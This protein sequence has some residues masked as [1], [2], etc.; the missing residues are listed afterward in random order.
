MRV[1]EKCGSASQKIVIAVR[2]RNLAGCG[3]GRLAGRGDFNKF[4]QENGRKMG[5]LL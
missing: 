3:P 1:A 2:M 4:V 5:V